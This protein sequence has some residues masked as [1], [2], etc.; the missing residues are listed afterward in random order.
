MPWAFVGAPE[1]GLTLGLSDLTV[2]ESAGGCFAD[3]QIVEIEVGRV[4]ASQYSAI[5][6]KAYSR[7]PLQLGAVSVAEIGLPAL[8]RDDRTCLAPISCL[9][10]AADSFGEQRECG[11]SSPAHDARQIDLA[12][13]RVLLTGLTKPSMYCAGAGVPSRCG[14]ALAD[15]SVPVWTLVVRLADVGRGHAGGRACPVGRAIFDADIAAQIRR[16]LDGRLPMSI[17]G[18]VGAIVVEHDVQSGMVGRLSDVICV[19]VPL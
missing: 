10:T 9:D 15:C 18:A 5:L 14:F 11:S 13:D 3:G 19:V 2:D 12:I 4:A 17:C 7:L 8:V 1:N 6:M 16:R